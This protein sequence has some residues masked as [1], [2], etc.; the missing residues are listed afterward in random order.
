MG[1]LTVRAVRAPREVRFAHQWAD[2]DAQDAG[3]SWEDHDDLPDGD[4]TVRVIADALDGFSVRPALADR[5]IVVRPEVRLMIPSRGS[6][7]LYVGTP[8]WAQ[9]ALGAGPPALDLPSQPPKE[10]WFGETPR[11][12]QLCYASRTS[13]RLSRADV[14]RWPARA[15]TAV[16]VRNEGREPLVLD[17][18]QVPTEGLALHAHPDGA[19]ETDS[20]DVVAEDGVITS[21]EAAIPEAGSLTPV[22]S[23]RQPGPAGLLGRMW[24][25]VLR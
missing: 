17:R 8:L 23:A 14:P 9:V 13:G 18:I 16:R 2:P 3:F 15:L 6:T 24:Q 20:V 7:T 21:V 22:A 5:P 4:H 10:T 11:E 25:R 12:G 1:A 19:L